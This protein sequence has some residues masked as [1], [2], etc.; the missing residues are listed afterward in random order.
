MF[1][2]P[3]TRLDRGVPEEPHVAGAGE[4]SASSAPRRTIAD[5]DPSAA[6]RT[7]EQTVVG[8]FWGRRAR[9]IEHR[10][11]Y[12]QCIRAVA[13]SQGLTTKQNAIPVCGREHGNGASGIAAWKEKYTY[14]VWRGVGCVRQPL[15]TVRTC[16]RSRHSRCDI[17][18]PL[19]SAYA[20]RGELAQ[21]DT[22][23]T[24]DGLW[25]R[26][27]IR[28]VLD[29]LG[30]PQTKYSRYQD[31]R[32]CSTAAHTSSLPSGHAHSALPCFHPL[33]CLKRSGFLI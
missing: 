19:P 7:A 18:L 33:H 3:L 27:P 21:H 30:A 22:P 4:E 2:P 5:L 26:E 23:K 28:S 31:A 10:L 32:V 24:N 1:E 29:A 25:R 11:V 9:E 6:E 14:H 15:A 20:A 13:N 16:R 8:L 17:P 12:N